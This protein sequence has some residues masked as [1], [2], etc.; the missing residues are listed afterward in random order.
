VHDE[1]S[2]GDRIGIGG[3][4]NNFP[5]VPSRHYLFIAGG[6]GVT[7]LL[8]MVHQANLLGADW[9]LVYGGRRRDTMGFLDELAEYGRRVHVLPEDEYGLLDPRAWLGEARDGT[10][11]YC[12]GPDGLLEA[13]ESA[14][15][16][17]PPYTLHTERFTPA[18]RS[19][20]VRDEPFEVELA[21]TGMRVTVSRATTVLDAVRTVGVEVLSSCE[22]GTCGTCETD[23]LA[24]IP[25]HRDSILSDDERAAG[26][27][28]FI[29]VSR[30]CGE[31]LVLDL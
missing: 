16:H 23:V 19:A 5:L 18:E 1:L 27:C 31:R 7:P 29:C 20:P 21:R 9:D 28:M 10:R 15:A 14:C 3:P 4:R 22:Q 6:I 12:C 17:W 2:V 30:S 13:I 26:E 8:P 11:V 25:D 24:G